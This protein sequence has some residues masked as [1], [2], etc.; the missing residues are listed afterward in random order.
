MGVFVL[1]T[2]ERGRCADW[3]SDGSSRDDRF[4]I[5]MTLSFHC[6]AKY[7]TAKRG[8]PV[9]CLQSCG[10]PRSQEGLP[11]DRRQ[12]TFLLTPIYPSALPVGSASKISPQCSN[13]APG[14]HHLLPAS[15]SGVQPPSFYTISGQ[16]YKTTTPKP[17]RVALS[18]NGFS[19]CLALCGVV[20]TL[21]VG[22]TSTP[23]EGS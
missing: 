16:C 14:G 10:F 4:N 19:F 12:H 1:I 5:S 22:L 21:T 17:S 18:S 3:P 23:E 13:P 20:T 2:A 6:L 15:G 11:S 7:Q 9:S 8:R